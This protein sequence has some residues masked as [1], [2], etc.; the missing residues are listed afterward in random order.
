MTSTA[1]IWA[2]CKTSTRQCRAADLRAAGFLV[3][4]DAAEAGAVQKPVEIALL[5][6]VRQSA[7]VEDVVKVWKRVLPIDSRVWDWR[8]HDVHPAHESLQVM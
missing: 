1:N 7:E 8:D 4:A 6:A 5:C 2:A 3:D